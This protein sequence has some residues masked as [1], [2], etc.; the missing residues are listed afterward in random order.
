MNEMT[1]THTYR[2]L[3]ASDLL[4]VDKNTKNIDYNND[5]GNQLNQIDKFV[6]ETIPKPIKEKVITPIQKEPQEEPQQEPQQE[7]RRSTRVRKTRDI[8]DL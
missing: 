6:K 2:R 5:R 8:L 3:F 1:H 7:L 4:K